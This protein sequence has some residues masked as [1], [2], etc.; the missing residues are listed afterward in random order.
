MKDEDFRPVTIVDP[1]TCSPM[2]VLIDA[3]AICHREFVIPCRGDGAPAT[4]TTSDGVT[5]AM[6]DREAMKL[7]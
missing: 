5:V 7:L 3:S 4:V 1:E 2:R 6:T